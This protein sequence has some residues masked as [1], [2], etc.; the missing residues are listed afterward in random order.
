V[1]EKEKEKER[2]SVVPLQIAE[3]EGTASWLL[4]QS[5]Q[6]SAHLSLPLL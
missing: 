5:H 3:D 1:R 6:S 4:N 2:V